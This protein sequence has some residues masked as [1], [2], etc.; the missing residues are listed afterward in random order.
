[1]NAVII[2]KGKYGA[3][4]QYAN[5]LGEEL[6]IEVKPADS[7]SGEQLKSYDVLLIG[8]SV[9]IGKLQI[10]K[11][12]KKNL[13]FMLGKKIFLFQVAG[14]PPEQVDKR[15]VYNL[16]GIP[17]ELTGKCAFY[18]LPG[19][20]LKEKL[21]WWDRFMLRM[22]ARLVKDPNE[23]KTMLTDYDLVKK[24]NLEEMI[25]AVNKHL[26]SKNLPSYMQN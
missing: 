20:M 4:R 26:S 5:W 3:T 1:M 24:E 13:D 19:R 23:R 7:I 6:E 16:D 25:L 17:S 10:K 15:Q 22:G 11:W 8:T 21:S 2:Y 14:T 18:F 12:I 9:Y